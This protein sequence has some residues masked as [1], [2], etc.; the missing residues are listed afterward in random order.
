M[1]RSVVI[2][3]ARVRAVVSRRASGEHG[4]ATEPASGAA[5]PV[6][7]AAQVASPSLLVSIG[8]RRLPSQCGYTC[9]PTGRGEG[10]D[11]VKVEALER[12]VALHVL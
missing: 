8:N 9:G 11:G 10:L 6:S 2:R 12:D 1:V 3:F 7:L 5:D 4:A